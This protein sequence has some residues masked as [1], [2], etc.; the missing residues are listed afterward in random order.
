MPQ[1]YSI[2][3]KAFLSLDWALKWFLWSIVLLKCVKYIFWIVSS[4]R[5]NYLILFKLSTVLYENVSINK[6]MISIYRS[7]GYSDIHIWLQFL[8]YTD[9]YSSNIQEI[10]SIETELH[11][12]NHT[13]RVTVSNKF[14]LLLSRKVSRRKNDLL[15]KQQE[16][17][18]H[19]LS[20]ISLCS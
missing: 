14:G 8:L 6:Q 13:S 16:T 10:L 15:Y 1:R 20:F 19:I 5:F 18:G 12:Q 2:I 3:N 17:W 4:K 11:R 7:S 9:L